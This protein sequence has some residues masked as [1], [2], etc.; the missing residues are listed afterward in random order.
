MTVTAEEIR[1][2]LN[3]PVDKIV[4]AVKN[5]LGKC[6]PELASDLVDSGFVL[7]GGGALLLGLAKRLANETG[8]PVRVAD[9]PAHAAVSGAAVVLQ[10]LNFLEKHNG[11]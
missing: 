10:E 8:L 9:D 11:R 4:G 1:G 3:E 7:T 5:T 6:E 2:A